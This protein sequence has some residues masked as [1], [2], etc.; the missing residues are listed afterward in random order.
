MKLEKN[1]LRGIVILAICLIVFNVIAFVVPFPKAGLFW[2]AWVFCNIAILA[3]A[4]VFILAFRNGE[5]VKS[6]FYG[7]PIARIGIIYLVVQL[8]TGFAA[9]GLAFIPNFPVWPFIIVFLIIFAVAAI[10]LIAADATR[11]EIERQDTVLKKDV[12]NMRG[13][14]S[15]GNSLLSQCSDPAV[16]AEIEKLSEQLRFSDPVSSNATAET[17]KEL[18]NL[19]DELQRALMEND[20]AGAA[21]LAKRAQAVLAERNRICKLNKSNS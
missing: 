5:S 8:I 18:S 14:Q 13:L 21:G 7:V 9:M 15:L 17:E 4:P 20:N 19:L 1:Q 10:G 3:Q 12:S 11:E 6:K 2:L 16:S